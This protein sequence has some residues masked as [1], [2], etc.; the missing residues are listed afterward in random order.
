MQELLMV[1]R[2]LARQAGDILRRSFVAPFEVSHKGSIDL[3]TSADKASEDF[4]RHFIG[5]EFPDHAILAE[6]SGGKNA[7][8]PYR[9]VI[10]PLDGTVNFAHRNPHWCV[11]IGV[12]ERQADGSYDTL[13]G[14]TYDPLRDEEFVAI[15]GG[16]ATLQGEP[17]RVS[18][19]HKLIN[20]LTATGFGYDRLLGK[21]DNHPE[22]CRLNL[23]TQGVRR[24]GSAGLDLA[25]VAC[26]R[27]DM[28]W[29][30]RL[31]P[32]DYTPGI[33]LV[34][35]AKGVVTNLTG[36]QVTEG[37][38]LASN[39]H[40]HAVSQRALQTAQTVPINSRRDMQGL[41]PE[42]LLQQLKD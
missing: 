25:Y 11:L 32:W 1:A 41:L 31:F 38:L 14:V 5:K 40:L 17:I 8:G 4:I 21:N 30:Y 16:G 42:D 13:Y 15:R 6:E 37:T 35:E 24:F 10:D 7:G 2:R 19:T 3:V 27:Y 36:G 29:E 33:L 26:G 20:A 22:F 28:Y 34:R 23:V 9:W 39:G 18:P 12:Q